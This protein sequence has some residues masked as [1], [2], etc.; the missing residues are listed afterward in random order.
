[1]IIPG[2][3]AAQVN[4]WGAAAVATNRLGAG[5]HDIALFAGDDVCHELLAVRLQSGRRDVEEGDGVPA[6]LAR[7]APVREPH[8][9]LA[10]GLG[11]QAKEVRQDSLLGEGGLDDVVLRVRRGNLGLELLFGDNLCGIDAAD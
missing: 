3:V 11:R 4:N 8:S 1:M 5:V 10:Q 9:G 2:S 6:A 7:V